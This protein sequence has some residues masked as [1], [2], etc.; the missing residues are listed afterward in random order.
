MGFSSGRYLPPAAHPL[1]VRLCVVV[2]S[3]VRVRLLRADLFA[4]FA[5]IHKAA[6]LHVIKEERDRDAAPVLASRAQ[7][8]AFT[9][10]GHGSVHMR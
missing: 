6:A 7:L 10:F 5:V 3:S 4:L 1:K 8:A 2:A 9:K